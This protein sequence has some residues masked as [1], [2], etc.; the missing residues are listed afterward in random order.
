MDSKQKSVLSKEIAQAT[1]AQEQSPT[2]QKTVDFLMAEYNVLREEITKRIEIEHQLVAL[3]LIAPATIFTI[4]FQMKDASLLFLYPALACLLSFVNAANAQHIHYTA[5]YIEKCIEPCM[6]SDTPL[7]VINR[8]GKI[9]KRIGSI[10]WQHYKN[11]NKKKFAFGFIMGALASRGIFIFT[12]LLALIL[13]LVKAGY[14]PIGNLIFDI[15][16][17]F[18]VVNIISIILGEGIT[19]EW[20]FNLPHSA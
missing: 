8:T 3:A 12:E 6:G 7:I 9:E 18:T 10:G 14:L 20:R 16:L 2:N 5:E 11:L 17:G 19:R 4:G 15:G 1:H 13:G